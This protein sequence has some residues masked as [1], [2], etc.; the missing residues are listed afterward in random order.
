M[1]S[2]LATRS[3]MIRVVISSLFICNACVGSNYMEVLITD[4][5]KTQRKN[6]S[7]IFVF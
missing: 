6:S 4:K 7:A 5:D 3:R 2:A 1:T